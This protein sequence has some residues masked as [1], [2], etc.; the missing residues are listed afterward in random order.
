MG[1]CAAPEKK[2]KKKIHYWVYKGPLNSLPA[3]FCAMEAPSEH[4]RV[5]PREDVDGKLFQNAAASNF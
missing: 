2:K 5:M 4:K 1:A 3:T